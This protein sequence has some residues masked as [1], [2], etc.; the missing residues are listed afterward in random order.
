MKPKHARDNPRL[1]A[2]VREYLAKGDSLYRSLIN[3]GVSHEVAQGVVPLANVG[4][5]NDPVTEIA[6]LSE[7][8]LEGNNE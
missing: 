2:E 4:Y 3:K 8:L 5:E 7:A 1:L 6:S